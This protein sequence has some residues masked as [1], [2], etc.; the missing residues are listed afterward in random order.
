MANPNFASLLDTPSVDVKAPPTFPAGPW[1]WRIIGQPRFDKSSKK[2]TE[3]V[4]FTLKPIAALEGV[5]QDDLDAFGEFKDKT[6]PATFYITDKA[7][8][9]LKEF[10][11]H[12]GI[13]EMD[14]EA[15]LTLR[16]RIDEAMNC[17]VIGDIR[18]EASED[19]QRVFAR[20]GK[21]APVE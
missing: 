16:Q 10:L 15:K 5:E 21:F 9:M 8:N 11:T 3:F 17:E 2:Q 14:G 1:H 6:L 18:H 12:C 20:F 4:E 7:L 19:G 13:P